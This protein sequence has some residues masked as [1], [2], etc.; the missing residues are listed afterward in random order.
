MI[1]SASVNY[2][3]KTFWTDVLTSPFHGFTESYTMV[4]A[5]LGLKWANGKVTTTL[6]GTN[7]LNDE[8]QQHVFGD[9]IKRSV[10]LEARFTF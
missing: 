4:N 8:I 5:S 2:T 1:G 9:L 7:L 10:F 3:D 6:K